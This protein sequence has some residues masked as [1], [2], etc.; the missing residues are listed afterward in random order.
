MLW[1]FFLYVILWKCIFYIFFMFRI[2][3]RIWFE[4]ILLF[5]WRKI[6]F[7]LKDMYAQIL[8][9]FSLYKPEPKYYSCW[10][11]PFC[12]ALRLDKWTKR[13]G[14]GG[15]GEGR[16]RR[17]KGG[18]RAF[19]KSKQNKNQSQSFYECIFRVSFF[20]NFSLFQ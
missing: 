12:L 14:K 20:R 16:K 15:L 11:V 3:S 7:L 5:G 6:F 1:W 19:N 10:I 17:Q 8:A 9:I 13:R 2:W 18:K 4:R